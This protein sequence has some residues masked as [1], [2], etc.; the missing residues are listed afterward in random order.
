MFLY[1][2]NFIVEIIGE[3]INILN[4]WLSI[5]V[6]KGIFQIKQVVIIVFLAV[7]LGV[8]IW[9]IRGVINF[10]NEVKNSRLNELQR[11]LNSYKLSSEMIFLIEED[12]MR[13]INYRVTGIS[14]VFIQK[15]ILQLFGKNKNL[16]SAD[17]FKKFRPF[18][19]IEN[20]VVVFK[21]GIYFWFDNSM[22]ILFALQ[23]FLTAIF[24]LSIP[25]Y[26]STDI[27]DW[28]SLVLCLMS[29]VM[30]LFSI[31]FWRM[32]TKPAECK[33]LEKIL[34]SQETN[35]SE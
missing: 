35:D 11:I 2:G 4:K 27:S 13:I 16:I 17:F 34:Q 21:K 24:I 14:N 29:I 28:E 3:L 7:P 25:I 23:L 30:F 19:Q 15:K 22:Y 32:I 12:I 18:L 33:L 31:G 1:G 10:F 8:V 6:D 5:S 26:K 20:D 9:K